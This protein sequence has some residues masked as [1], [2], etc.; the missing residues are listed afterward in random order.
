MKTHFDPYAGQDDEP[1]EKAGCGT[2]LGNEYKSSHKW[3]AV[4]CKRCLNAKQKLIR[5]CE[6]TEKIILDQMG[7]MA[8]LWRG[9]GK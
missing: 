9:E 5:C 3:D 4:T 1:L 2:I 6:E 8:A 7:G